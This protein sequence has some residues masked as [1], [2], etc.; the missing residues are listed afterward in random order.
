MNNQEILSIIDSQ[1]KF[2]NQGH[3]KNVDFRILQLKK[4]L[5]AIEKH[6]SEII[7]TIR[8][9]LGRCEVDAYLGDVSGLKKSIQ[10]HIQSVKAWAKPQ[11][12][13]S[14]PG[15]KNFIYPEPLGN[16]LVISPWNYPFLVLIDPLIGVISA[17]N[18]AVLKPSEIS[19][20][21]AKVV[22][23]IIKETFESEYIAVI[24]GGVEE[25]QFLLEQK[26]NHIFFTGST[27]VGKI[28]YEAAAKNLTPV[29]LELGG[30]SPVIVDKDID[31]RKT[32]NRL[33][34]GKTFNTGQTC[35][36]PDYVFVDKRIKEK[37]VQELIKSIK[38]FFGEN[39]QESEFYSRIINEK[40]FDRL[41]Q[42]LNDGKIIY[43]G[44]TDRADLYIEPTLIE[45]ISYDNKIMQEEI[46]GPILPIFEYEDI[47]EVIGFITS[48]PKPLALYVF[49]K[50]K[51]FCCNIV[52]KTSAG[53][54]S[55]NDTLMHVSF[56]NLPFGGVGYSGIG[57]YHGKF[58]FEAL[59]NMKS[60]FKNT[61]LFD[62][63]IIYPPFKL[64]FK[65]MKKIIDTLT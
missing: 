4:L 33:I 54:M 24:Q 38:T 52:Q 13:K 10:Y 7:E 12:V 25:T 43:G 17:G 39:P 28:V 40:Q 16:V 58:G 35:T 59:S 65:K 42:Y 61:F 46:F 45:G 15:G 26:F 27:Q 3:T 9:D 62:R 49:S 48:R 56:D 8:K 21:T 22:E 34:W 11:K 51:K 5:G 23:K 47:N 37:F 55:I 53:G 20:N 44:K 50:N 30:K 36:A 1:R 19:C 63:N 64:G 31:F 14:M 60:I 57:K 18:T 32:A 6:E 29:I 41:S 2:F